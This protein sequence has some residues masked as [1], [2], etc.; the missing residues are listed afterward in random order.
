MRLVA[1]IVAALAAFAGRA[2]VTNA[3]DIAA[4]VDAAKAGVA[5]TNGWTLSGLSN[6]SESCVKFDTKGDW[7]V[8][9]DYGSRIVCVE[10]AVRCSSTAPTRWLK[11]LDG[12]NDAELTSFAA[13]AKKDALE[14]QSIFLDAACSVSRVKLKLEGSGN[15]GVWGIG[16]LKVITAAAIAAPTALAVASANTDSFVL[17]W[18]NDVNAASNRIDVYQIEHGEGETVLFETDFGGF[19]GSTAQ[20]KDYTSRV[21]EMLGDAFSGVRVYGA[22]GMTGVCQLGAGKELGILRYA[23]LSSYAGVKLSMVAKQYPGDNAQ[24]SIAYEFCGTTNE[25]ETIALPVEFGDRTVDLSA[26]P[27]DAA[28]L[29]G[30]YKT[31]SNRRVLLDSMSIVRTGTVVET[32][33]GS[34]FICASPGHADFS[35]SGLF[36]LMPDST[37]RF[38]VFAQNLDGF[39]SS[40]ASVEARTSPFASGFEMILR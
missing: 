29:M 31:K 33:V 8:S 11:V 5:E 14:D 39:L 24:T 32:F 28:I 15:A 12:R 2:A 35:T 36:S 3:A 37:Y 19:N 22:A 16:G 9:P 1:A 38:H 7:L 34:R 25:V 18:E 23:G 40:A 27:G 20:T 10:A 26:V 21:P 17:E 13:C 30:Y 4:L 6:Y